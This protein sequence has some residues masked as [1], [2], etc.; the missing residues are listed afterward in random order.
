MLPD[1]VGYKG[2]AKSIEGPI[3][4]FS[5]QLLNKEETS[6]VVSSRAKLYFLVKVVESVYKNNVTMS[7][8]DFHFASPTDKYFFLESLNLKISGTDFLKYRCSACELL[9]YLYS[10]EPVGQIIEY[11]I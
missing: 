8:S 4:R 10:K 7:L 2:K 1:G 11:N 9:I 3:R 6:I 5:Y